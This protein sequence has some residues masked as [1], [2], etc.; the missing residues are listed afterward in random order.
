MVD[1]DI[2]V[3]TNLTRDHLDYHKTFEDYR[4]AKGMLFEKLTDPNRQRAVINLDDPENEFFIAK[5][6]N[7]PTLTYSLTNPIADVYAKNIQYSLFE[8]EFDVR[9]PQGE[10]SIL[11]ALVGQFN[12]QNML[13]AIATGL[14]AGISLASI[15]NGIES[16]V[17][18]PGRL[19]LIDIGQPFAVIVDY[20]HTPDALENVLKTVRSVG[21]KRILTGASD[22]RM[23]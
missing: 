11:S 9:T 17:G 2:A 10:L 20:A 5:A 14:A 3:F 7:V 6:K 13:A 21:A 16:L 19:E 15:K 12:V 23:H 1:Y 4:A 22:F 18:V 8:T